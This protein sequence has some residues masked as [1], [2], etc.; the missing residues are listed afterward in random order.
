[1]SDGQ[2]S[3]R[4]GWG[5]T[6]AT[7]LSVCYSSCQRCRATEHFFAYEAARSG[8]KWSVITGNPGDIVGPILSP[9]QAVETWQGK[10]ATVLSGSP[11][12]QE[13]G[14]PWMLVDARD[15]AEAEILLA[16]STNIQS[17][18]RFLLS[19]GDKSASYHWRAYVARS[20]GWGQ[21]GGGQ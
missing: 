14:R 1:V 10:I 15:V 19:S 4:W 12:I 3:A 16:E 17:G 8:G 9:H 13:G 21:G 6:S 11:T 5:G 20:W 2:L 7:Y 18:E